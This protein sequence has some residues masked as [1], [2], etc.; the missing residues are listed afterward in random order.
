MLDVE[1]GAQ[2]DRFSAGTQHI[3]D[4]AAAELGDRVV[5][6]AAVQRI[7]CHDRRGDGHQRKG[8]G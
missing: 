8:P 3:A 5:L 6:E 2:Q 7:D 1:N 4:T